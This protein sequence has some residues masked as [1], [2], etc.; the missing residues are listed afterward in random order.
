MSRAVRIEFGRSE[1]RRNV[2]LADRPCRLGTRV[3]SAISPQQWFTVTGR[4]W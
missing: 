4:R 3:R 1:L 2:L